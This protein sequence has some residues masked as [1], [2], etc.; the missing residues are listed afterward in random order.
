VL[1]QKITEA[2]KAA[3]KAG[4]AARTSALRLIL[5]R[6][7]ETDINARGRGAAEASEEELIAMLRSM[8]KS[9]RESI[10][11]YREGNRPELAA[12]EEA[13]IAVIEEFLPPAM[14]EEALAQAVEAAIAKTGASSAKDMGKVMA[15]IKAE[16]GSALD[17]AAASA[18]V[19]QRLAS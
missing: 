7:K 14:S 8:I 18:L 2:L 17:M 4:D 16:H 15:A 5:A 19:R 11:L 12:K 9:R 3:M 10:A 13:E 6:L 1:R